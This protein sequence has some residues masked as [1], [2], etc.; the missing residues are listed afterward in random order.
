MNIRVENLYKKYGEETILKDINIDIKDREAV[1]LLGV[2]G[3]GKSTLLR[4]LSGIECAYEGLIR[5]D[6]QEVN[7]RAF[8]EKIA[9]VFQTGSLFPHLTLMNNI[10]L[11]LH[12]IK[13]VPKKEAI[14]RVN[15]LLERFSLI[16]HKDKYPYQLSGGQEQR[17]S[18]VRSLALGA[19][20]FFF[21][22]PTSALDPILTNEVLDTITELRLLGK[23]FIIV[24]HE[25]AFAKRAADY[26]F[27]LHESQ[28][29]EQG[30]ISLIDHP[31]TPEFKDFLDKV[32]LNH[33]IS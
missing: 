30:D 10:V 17:A 6:E 8:K 31:Q 26:V 11:I 4:L 33:P 9:F 3:S 21:D 28:I 12:K 23:K 25:I 7:T 20:I 13:K 22:E 5:I 15:D 24:T 32:L 14:E 2:S 18:I 1:V 19:E 27:F 29:I 16:E